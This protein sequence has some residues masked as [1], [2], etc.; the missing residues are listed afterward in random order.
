MKKIF[1]FLVFLL[2]TITLLACSDGQKSATTKENKK[3][4]FNVSLST[5]PSQV[6]P[7]Q[8][9]KLVFS[10]QDANTK[11]LGI[12][13]LEIVHEKPMHLIIVSEDL[14]FFNHIHPQ[15]ITDTSVFTVDTEFPNAGKYHFYLDYSP[16]SVGHRLARLELSVTGTPPT[17]VPLV[18]DKE[19][20]KIVE[21]VK[22]TFK[23]EKALQA[24]EALTL[25][26]LLQD[27]K[28][29]QPL[30]DIE[31][32]LG[33]FAHFNIVNQGHTEVLHAH[34]LKEATSKDERGGPEIGTRTIFPK[35]GI[36]K[37]W[38][39]F[40]RNGKVIVA[41]F[42]VS[43]T[44]GKT[45]SEAILAESSSNTQKLK[46]VVSEN[47]FEPN[48]L[49]LKADIPAQ[50]TFQRVDEKNCAQEVLF[51][52]LGIRKQLP[53]GQEVLVEFTPSKNTNYEFT[54]GMGMLRG[55]VTVK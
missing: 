4:Y 47:G 40:Q 27:A 30:T 20:S 1:F 52:E 44:E 45:Q 24:G 37:I 54:C 9:T 11:E 38:A 53:L 23:P 19:N 6:K 36:Y 34:P 5:E 22:V 21:G 51:T 17:P 32:Y 41:P 8:S 48:N 14:S 13:D 26:F 15:P 31:P 50:I 2:I 35:A 33:A 25:A 55:T 12:N 7:N 39:Q 10:I 43:V 3:V 42:I 46:I 28:T 16:K 49:A 29:E 18:V